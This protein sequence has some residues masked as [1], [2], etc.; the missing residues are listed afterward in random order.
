NTG[1]FYVLP[2]TQGSAAGPYSFNPVT[3]V[4]TQIGNNSLFGNSPELAMD[5]EDHLLL[6][7]G[8][9]I[10]SGDTACGVTYMSTLPG[11]NFAIQ[12]P[13]GCTGGTTTLPGCPNFA[14]WAGN[15]GNSNSYWPGLVYDEKS[16][17]FLFFGGANGGKIVV[18]DPRSW[19]CY[20]ETYGSTQ[21][22][23]QP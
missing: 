10:T 19:S 22:V 21:D 16:R 18:L 6:Y 11:S 7:A 4:W 2:N 20:T 1:L 8:S 15:G 3:K 5:P 12:F 23:D 13:P 9:Q 17:K 14:S